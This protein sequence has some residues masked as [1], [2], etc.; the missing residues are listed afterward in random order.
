MKADQRLAA[1]C[2]LLCGTFSQISA[3]GNQTQARPTVTLD[4]GSVIGTSTTLPSASVT[5][6][7][8][9]GIPYG[10]IPQRFSPATPATLNSSFD[11]S[12]YGPGCIQ[13][14]NAPQIAQQIAKALYNTPPPL[15]GISEDCLS[16]NIFAPSTP[17]TGSGRSVLFF[18]PGGKT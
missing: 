17:A 14:F 16:L 6:N 1:A 7:Q 5:V 12:R 8:F 18:I 2:L 3:Q 13:Q 15:G 9:L 11:A 10:T 4:S